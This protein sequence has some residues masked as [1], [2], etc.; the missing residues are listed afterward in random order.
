MAKTIL[1]SFFETRYS[2]GCCCCCC[3]FN[4]IACT[5]LQT[6][7]LS[8]SSRSLARCCCF[9][10]GRHENTPTPRRVLCAAVKPKPHL[11]RFVVDLLHTTWCTVQQLYNWSKV[12]SKLYGTGPYKVTSLKQIRKFWHLQML[13]NFCTTCCP[14]SSQQIQVVEFGL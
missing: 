3:C 2:C 14:S 9:L 10:S 12:H 13:Y 7:G 5:R 6:D 1:H 4:E 8:P 11:L